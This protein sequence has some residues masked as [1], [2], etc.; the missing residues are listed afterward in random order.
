MFKKTFRQSKTD[1]QAYPKNPIVELN[2]SNFIVIYG[3]NLTFNE[4]DLRFYDNEDQTI[5]FSINEGGVV[6]IIVTILFIDSSFSDI[7]IIL[8]NKKIKIELS[9]IFRS[10]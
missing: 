9:N 3:A 10:E 2:K 7:Q 1:V 5:F 6:N 8:K 4:L